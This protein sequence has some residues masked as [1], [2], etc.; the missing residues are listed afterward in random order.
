MNLTG[1]VEEAQASYIIR[2]FETELFE[3]RKAA[4]RAIADG[5]NQELGSERVI[6]GQRP[7]LQHEAGSFRIARCIAKAVAE[8][9]GYP[10]NLSSLFDH[11]N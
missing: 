3:N 5:M 2:D 10:A 1:T 11:W 8:K 9:F 6:T 7:V 4:M